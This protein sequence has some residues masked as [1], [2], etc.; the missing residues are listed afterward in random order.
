MLNIIK[1][2]WAEISKSAE[3]K[4]LEGAT[5]HY[6][7]EQRMKRIDRRQAPF[8]SPSFDRLDPVRRF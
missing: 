8:Q 5:D 7:L 1:N 2:W 4:Y 6:D 3:Q